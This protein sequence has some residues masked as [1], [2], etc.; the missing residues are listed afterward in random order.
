MA[1][2]L[3]DFNVAHQIA[4]RIRT[5]IARQDKGDVTAAAR[6]LD[7]P[8]ADVYLPERIIGSGNE[9]AALE[10]LATVVRSSDVLIQ[11]Q[12]YTS[13]CT[14]C[15]VQTAED[16]YLVLGTEVLKCEKVLATSESTRITDGGNCSHETALIGRSGWLLTKNF[17]TAG[18]E[19]G[20]PRGW[21]Y[22]GGELK[23]ELEALGGMRPAESV[24]YVHALSAA[25]RRA[26]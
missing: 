9:P 19:A 12:R 15:G 6:R 7:L 10:F 13:I 1:V 8:I 16:F 20:K 4:G 25:P 18:L 24:R 26:Q 21:N 14:R 23:K 11:R 5:L 2:H 17:E 3:T 22:R